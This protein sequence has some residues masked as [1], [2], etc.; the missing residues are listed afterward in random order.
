MFWVL[1][2]GVFFVSNIFVKRGARAFLR[3]FLLTCFGVVC[4][5]NFLLGRVIFWCLSMVD[6]L[7]LLLRIFVRGNFKRG[8]YNVRLVVVSFSLI[9]TR[10]M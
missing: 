4:S 9:M 8:S 3:F 1:F 6:I 7:S 5:L 10:I 2:A